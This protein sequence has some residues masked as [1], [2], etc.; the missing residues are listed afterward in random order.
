MSTRS[1]NAAQMISRLDWIEVTCQDRQYRALM[2]AQRDRLSAA[3]QK[4]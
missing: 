4:A 2:I 1:L 3:I